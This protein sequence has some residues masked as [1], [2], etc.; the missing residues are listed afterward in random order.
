MPSAPSPNIYHFSL[1]FTPV[2]FCWTLLLRE[3]STR[4]SRTFIQRYN[5]PQ[6]GVKNAMLYKLPQYPYVWGE[7][8]LYIQDGHVCQNCNRRHPTDANKFCFAISD[9]CLVPINDFQ[10][11]KTNGSLL[12]F[13]FTLWTVMAQLSFHVTK[14]YK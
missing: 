5:W 6:L 1:F 14:F 13:S 7:C 10:L 3:E 4:P 12:I 9:G 11:L 2:S 8:S